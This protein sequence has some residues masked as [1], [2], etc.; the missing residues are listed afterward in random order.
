MPAALVIDG[1]GRIVYAYRSRRIDERAQPAAIAAS[2]R[3]PADP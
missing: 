3:A 2:L 1:A